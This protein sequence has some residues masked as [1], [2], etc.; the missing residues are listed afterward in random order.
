MSSSQQDRAASIRGKVLAVFGR[1]FCDMTPKIG[2]V[3]A[4]TY[5]ILMTNMYLIFEVGHLNRSMSLL[6]RVEPDP[7]LTI[8]WVIPYCYYVAI[9]LALITFPITI[10]F[11]Y[12][13]YH[14]DTTG[15]FIYLGWVGFYDISNCVIITLT[16]MA[17]KTAAFSIHSLEWVGLVTAFY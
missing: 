3:V 7:T 12:S 10:F 13:V 16:S 6:E 1:G 4:G 8:G 9:A 5:M 15:I 14:Q 2:S 11:I 17:A